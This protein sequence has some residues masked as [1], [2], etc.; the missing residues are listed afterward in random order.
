[1]SDEQK[2]GRKPD[3]HALQPVTSGKGENVRTYWNRV[4]AGWLLEEKEG[5]RVKLNSFP[6]DGEFILM[7]PKEENAGN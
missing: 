1:M 7:P 4:G 2:K 6:V 5:V 3:F